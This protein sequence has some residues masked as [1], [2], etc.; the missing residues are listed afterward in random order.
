V[1]NLAAAPARQARRAA[2]ETQLIEELK[3]QG[4]P[5]MSGHGEVF[6]RYPY[7]GKE[8]GL[9]DRYLKGEKL[10]TSWVNPT[11]AEPS[12]IE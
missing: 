12:P 5:R 3:Q 6:D 10:D 1:N 4:D 9:Y 11:D 8:R 7:A 2:L